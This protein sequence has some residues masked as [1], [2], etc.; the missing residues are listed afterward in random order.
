MPWWKTA[1][2]ERIAFVIGYPI[3]TSLLNDDES[4]LFGKINKNF[5]KK[6]TN[7]RIRLCDIVLPPRYVIENTNLLI[8][9]DYYIDH[10]I[11]PPL[12]RMFIS[13]F[14]SLL[15]FFFEVSRC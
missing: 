2:G 11:L 1:K 7:T 13:L 15:F 6:S 3:F 10:M 4:F 12:H 9:N 8:N 14:F 5:V